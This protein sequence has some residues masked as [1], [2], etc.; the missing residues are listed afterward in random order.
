MQTV[1][2]RILSYAQALPEGTLIGAKE[3][4][5]LGSRAAVDQALKRLAK[6]DEL[7]RLAHGL[8]A[9]PVKTRFGIRAPAA[10]K[11]IEVL[12]STHAETIV[13][14]GAAAANKLGLT[15]QVPTK[16]VY[17]TS[18]PDRQFRLGAQTVEMRHA[19]HWMLL[20][21]DSIAGQ[22]IRA[23]AWLGEREAGEALKVLKRKLPHDTLQDLVA[24]RRAMPPWMSKSVSQSLLNHG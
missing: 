1:A 3:V 23:L 10:E 16:L 17:L 8:Y 14:H 7:M 9:L 13:P 22:A 18:G 19:P 15:T 12:A 20:P 24:L 21:T 5:H 2:E 11:V 6:R 4:L